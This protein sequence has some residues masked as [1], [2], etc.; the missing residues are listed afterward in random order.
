MSELTKEEAAW[1][2]KLQKCLDVCPSERLGFAT[3]GDPSVMVFD[4]T[5]EREIY[6][7]MDA[8]KG[9]FMPVAEDLDAE[10]FLL[11]FPASV[12]STAW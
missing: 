6:A 3:T 8:G 5:K 4:R 9:D 7:I 11:R 1:L 2:R 12:H 10:L